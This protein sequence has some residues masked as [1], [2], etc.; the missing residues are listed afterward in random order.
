MKEKLWDF[1]GMLLPQ[2]ARVLNLIA[3][4]RI[5]KKRFLRNLQL[6]KERLFM[7]TLCIFSANAVK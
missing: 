3:V 1:T 4:L 2:I 7:E 6:P 5:T